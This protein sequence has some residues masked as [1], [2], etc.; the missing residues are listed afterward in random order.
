MAEEQKSQ[1]VV[2]TYKAVAAGIASVV[3]AVFTS[4]LGVAGTLIGTA[5]TAILITLISAALKAQLEKASNTISGLPGAVQGRL[6]TQ[7]LRIPG[8][9]NPEPNPEPTARP[10]ATGRG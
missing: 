5:L 9:P 7:Q 2:K 6:S 8:K 4:K 10:E 1:K 3:T